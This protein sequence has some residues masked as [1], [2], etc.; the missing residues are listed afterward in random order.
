MFYQ[1]CAQIYPVQF[2]GVKFHGVIFRCVGVSLPPPSWVSKYNF[3]TIKKYFTTLA[4]AKEYVY[5][6]R[7]KYA[8]KPQYPPNYMSRLFVHKNPYLI[9]SHL[10]LGQLSLF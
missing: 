5:S 7:S 2:G 9:N 1:V 10:V 6:L 3:H 8:V 4:Q